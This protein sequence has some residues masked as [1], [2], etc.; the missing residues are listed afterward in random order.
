ML[1]LAKASF[2]YELDVF[3]DPKDIDIEWSPRAETYS[4]RSGGSIR[5]FLRLK[6]NEHPFTWLK[7]RP[8]EEFG[9]KS[10]LIQNASITWEAGVGGCFRYYVVSPFKA[11][12]FTL[13][14]NAT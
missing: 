3:L 8:A 5:F 14:S 4:S 10:P 7:I 1:K 12:A 6:E 13:K 11:I 9:K 2:V